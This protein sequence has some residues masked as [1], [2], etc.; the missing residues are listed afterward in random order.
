M[1]IEKFKDFIVRNRGC[2]MMMVKVPGW[3]RV[4]SIIDP[5]D[6]Y[7]PD[8]D[9]GISK[10]P[11]VT[12]LYGF[13]S[14]IMPDDVLKILRLFKQPQI[15]FGNIGIFEDNP[16]FDVVMIEVISEDLT[17]MNAALS[18]LPNED[19]FP[20]YHPHVT[21]AYV[22]K[23]AARKYLN[24]K[25]DFPTGTELKD[26]VYSMTTGQKISIELNGREER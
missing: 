25:V 3:D 9:H 17:K 13:Y 18:V 4:C 2:V 26:A 15:Q 6:I 22:K 23:G 16:D 20:T 11:H 19:T 12:V 21:I 7:E 8:E 5:D 10:N 1:A 14:Y 24:A